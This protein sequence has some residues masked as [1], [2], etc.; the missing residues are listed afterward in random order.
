MHLIIITLI[1]IIIF[2]YLYKNNYE[3]MQT[4]SNDEKKYDKTNMKNIT[5]SEQVTNP[6]QLNT[7]PLFSN[8]IMYQNDDNYDFFTQKLGIN[9]CIEDKKCHTCVEFGVTG[10]AYCF[11]SNLNTSVNQPDIQTTIQSTNKN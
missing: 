8:V 1:L 2:Y 5:L 6:I 3:H 4:N 10:A 9:K 11:P 7:D